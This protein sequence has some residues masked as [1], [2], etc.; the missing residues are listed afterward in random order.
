LNALTDAHQLRRH[1][2]LFDATALVVGSM[3]GSA[4]FF[5][6][7][8]MAQW[9]ATPGLL[10]GLWV[11]GG[12]F[13]ML[14]AISCAELAAMYPHA[15]GQYVFLRAAY[16]DFWAFLFGWTQFLVIQTGFNA[17]VAIAFA[18]YLGVLLPRLGEAT[19]LARIPLGELLPPAVQSHLP[20]S[21]LHWELNSAQVVACGVIALLTGVNIRGVRE[22]AFVQNL[23]TVLKVIALLALIAA[24]LS[25]SGGAAHFFPLLQPAT[26]KLALQTGFL[27]GLAVA[28]SKALFAYDAW[29]TVTF[30]AEEVHD[31]PR[32]LPRALLLG[33]LLVTVLYVL[34][35]VAYMVV[36]PVDQIAAVAE[37]RVA[38]RVA[39]VLFGHVGST[40][41]IA[42]ILASTFGCLNG[43]IL[44]GARVCYAMAREGLFFRHC[45]RLNARRTP[46]AALLYQGF[47]S[48]V[49][50]LSGSYS[51]LL[52]YSTFA[53]VLFSGLTVAAVYRL[54]FSQPERPRPYRCWGYPVTPALYLAISLAFLVYVV[55]GDPQA[56]MLGL[57]LVFTGIPFYLTWKSK[58]VKRAGPMVAILACVALV[59]GTGRS[60]A[61]DAPVSAPL[62][63]SFW[64]HAS[65][66]PVAQR[67]YWGPAF[68]AA[69]A[70]TDMEIRAAARLLTGPYAANRLYL[71]YHHE[72]SLDEAQRA[73]ASW[74]RYCPQAVQLVPTLLLRMYDPGQS[75]VFTPAELRRLTAFFQ[76]TIPTGPIAVY[77]VQAH[78]DQG[79][80]LE[81]LAKQ[82][83]GGLIRVGIQPDEKIRPPFIAAVQDT[84]SGFCH[85]KTNADWQ[86]PG[87]GAERLRQ[88]VRQRNQEPRPVAWD[89][90]VVAWDY[91]ATARGG[92]PGY[93]D[94]DRN[95]PLPSG[96][97]RLAA[98]EILRAAQAGRC[99]G[100]SSDLLILQA[101]SRSP[102]H[103]G[104]E[105][106]FYQTLKRGEVYRGYYS[107]P[108]Q[109]IV[110][111]FKGF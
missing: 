75:T 71:V 55:R 37:N 22:G 85:G 44:G 10:V 32:T 81:N 1:L 108:F 89:L 25:R 29:Y 88:W 15:G 62:E 83:P 49:L 40:L 95:M 38:E 110:A 56:T 69:A 45:A 11:F 109:E 105:A 18:K 100:F 70:A 98:D 92:Y 106:S 104:A 74:R 90:I 96:R 9:V 102:A 3:I 6:L 42:A 66:A 21:L 59:A 24:G 23:F 67:G 94:A 86:S 63:R 41:V 87:F 99:G 46:V 91:A 76:R 31:S 58:A 5:G 79:P 39:V 28:L 97:N 2:G 7:S 50:A 72:V 64:L 27:A 30:V 19:L 61:A 60:A 53:S 54:R 73:F 52:T 17:A 35:N 68:P 84:W 34:T 47:W 8:I 43:L 26:G 16:G 101:N 77:D 65:L 103:D 111:I 57:L 107:V 33:C 12:L 20:H 51:E 80:S 82:C 14:G 48:M 4:I 93:D 78:R 13:T 36:L